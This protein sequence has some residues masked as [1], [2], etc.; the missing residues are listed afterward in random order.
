MGER[1]PT[2]ITMGS[3]HTHSFLLIPILL[4][5]PPHLTFHIQGVIPF[6]G[7]Y[8]GLTLPYPL[9][10][11]S[12]PQKQDWTKKSMSTSWTLPGI[13]SWDSTRQ[14]WPTEL[15]D[16]WT[17]H[18][19]S[20]SPQ[21]PQTRGRTCC[22]LSPCTWLQHGKGRDMTWSSGELHWQPIFTNWTPSFTHSAGFAGTLEACRW[23]ANW[24]HAGVTITIL[25][26][27]HSLGHGREKV[28]W[29]VA[30][31]HSEKNALSS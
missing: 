30:F 13:S 15:A 29:V 8:F 10:T 20:H 31:L 25:K 5:S 2:N 14:N 6:V 9:K 22:V 19:P 3:F 17:Y 28:D 27:Y 11:R 21:M 12:Y 7:L 16:L 4:V 24:P 26:T 23:Q 18:H 1:K